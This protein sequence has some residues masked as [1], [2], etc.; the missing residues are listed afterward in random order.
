MNSPPRMSKVDNM[1]YSY[2][3]QPAEAGNCRLVQREGTSA[4][5]AAA[6]S[7]QRREQFFFCKLSKHKE[8]GGRVVL[9]HK[10]R[11]KDFLIYANFYHH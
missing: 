6:S 10:K 1:R 3:H 9:T 7:Y 5:A 4:E 2:S 8:E 11:L